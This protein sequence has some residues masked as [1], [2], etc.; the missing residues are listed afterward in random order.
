MPV[1]IRP[2]ADVIAWAG[3]DLPAWAED[4]R[5]MAVQSL[6]HEDGPARTVIL[7]AVTEDGQTVGFLVLELGPGEAESPMLHFVARDPERRGAGIGRALFR[8][9]CRRCC[10]RPIEAMGVGSEGP[11]A[12]RRWGF[13][14]RPD[15][16][17]EYDGE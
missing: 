16:F 17:W 6:Q 15:G 14:L 1:T 4:A 13:V 7:E 11:A 3:S 8:E 9:A 5:L 12:M 2:V 10:G